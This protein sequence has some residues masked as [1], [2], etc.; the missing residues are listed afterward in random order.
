MDPHPAS[1]TPKMTPLSSGPSNYPG[2]HPRRMHLVRAVSIA[3]VIVGALLLSAACARLLDRRTASTTAI[4]TEVEDCTKIRGGDDPLYR[5]TVA[6]EYVVG[7]APHRARGLVAMRNTTIRAGSTVAVWYDPR[8]PG[9]ATTK[10]TK[11]W[12]VGLAAVV[13]I[14]VGLASAAALK[15][16]ADP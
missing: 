2:R 12:K 3:G 9:R 11:P 15:H 10:L 7:G 16:R 14:G 4:V 8:A 5:C 6:A 13:G 1:L